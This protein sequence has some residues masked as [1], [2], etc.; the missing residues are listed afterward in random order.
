ME[1]ARGITDDKER[2]R[3]YRRAQ[4][5]LFEELPVLPIYYYR[6]YMFNWPYV[7]EIDLFPPAYTPCPFVTHKT[8]MDK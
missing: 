7:R 8:W 6:S 2:A 1:K 3:V 4:D 5:I